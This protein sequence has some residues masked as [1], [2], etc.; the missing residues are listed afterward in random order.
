MKNGCGTQTDDMTHWSGVFLLLSCCWLSRLTVWQ[1]QFGVLECAEAIS[2]GPELSVVLCANIGSRSL[3]TS[4][5]VEHTHNSGEAF[6]RVWAAFFIS[7]ALRLTLSLSLSSSLS[8]FLLPH[9]WENWSVLKHVL[10]IT[11][12][13]FSCFK[14]ATKSECAVWIFLFFSFFGGELKG[15][16]LGLGSVWNFK[17]FSCLFVLWFYRALCLH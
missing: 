7:F 4:H 10:N 1:I 5:R 2:T 17:P 16:S 15:L 3:S 13:T 9:A 6:Y 12:F 14:K 11:I 8:L